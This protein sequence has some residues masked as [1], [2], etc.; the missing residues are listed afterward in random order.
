MQLLFVGCFYCEFIFCVWG[1]SK[2]KACFF[3]C[4]KSNVLDRE[5][6]RLVLNV[7]GLM[8]NLKMFFMCKKQLYCIDFQYIMLIKNV[9]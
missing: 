4:K 9:S 7:Q 3:M 5:F 1:K 2:I 8:T 6:N